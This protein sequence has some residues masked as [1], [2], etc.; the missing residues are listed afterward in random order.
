M[1]PATCDEHGRA[2]C[3]AG[4]PPPGSSPAGKA[5]RH[6]TDV[7]GAARAGAARARRASTQCQLMPTED[8]RRTDATSRTEKLWTI[9]RDLEVGLLTVSRADGSLHARPVV[10]HGDESSRTLW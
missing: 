9:I 8:G 1:Y 2:A 6:P 7:S 10:V 4:A 3:N 5:G